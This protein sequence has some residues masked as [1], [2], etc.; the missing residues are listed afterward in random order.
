MAVQL[1][2]LRESDTAAHEAA[3]IEQARGMVPLLKER[4]VETERD[5]RL[6]DATDALFREAG[7]YRILQPARYGGMELDYGVQTRLAR[8][9][10]RGC[11]SSAWVCSILPCH[12]WVV[13]MFPDPQS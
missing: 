2:A 7:L 11:A 3:L 6:S 9:L 13:G 12:G 8:E 4:A 5:R 1:N 10:G